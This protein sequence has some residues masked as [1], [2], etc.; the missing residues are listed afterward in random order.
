MRILNIVHRYYPAIGGAENYIKEISERLVKD[1]HSVTVFTTDAYDLQHFW[2]HRKRKIAL[3]RE[4]CNGVEIERFH[5]IKLLFHNILMRIFYKFPTLFFKSMFS[6]PS[7]LVP[8][9]W[10]RLFHDSDQGFDMVHVSALPY[11]SIMYMAMRYAKRFKIPLI[12]TPF[13]HLGE[14]KND[15]VNR[16]YTR[17]FQIRLLSQ[18]DKLIVQTAVER[19]FLKN[20]GID[21]KKVFILGQGVNPE[22]VQG[23]DGER[24]RKRF[25]I[26]EERIVFHLANMSYDKGTIN[27]VEA[28][29]KIWK[30]DSN[31]KLV[32]A[33]PTMEEFNKYFS[34]QEKNVQN[35]CLVL[36]RVF[37]NVKKD[38]FAAGDVFAMPSRTDSYGAV[39]L[40]A[41]ANKKPVIGARAGG[42]TEVIRHEQDGY[43]T[44][45]SNIDQLA[46][47]IEKL[48]YDKSLSKVMGE[49]G[50]TKVINGLTWDARYNKF[51][52]ILPDLVV[53]KFEK[54]VK[55]WRE[56]LT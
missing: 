24:F 8:G 25:G 6:L 17:D 36:D 14:H 1:G 46:Y 9:M 28:L 20:S 21:E 10:K 51:K 37:G 26:N 48:L 12:A 49:Q 15:S 39:Y 40:E 31:V 13:L 52:E 4:V 50:Y 45:F 29:K 16:Y 33:G 22:N 7:P 3:K 18:C 54:V 5:V 42:V 38:L 23:G 32:L 30:K 53:G 11:N 43:L 47:Y 27:L 44:E 19:N 41:W 2:K 35:K 55:E 34:K 56:I